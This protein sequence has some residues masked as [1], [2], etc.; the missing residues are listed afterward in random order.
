LI[1]VLP[2]LLALA[3]LVWVFFMLRALLSL[4]QLAPKGQRMQ[5]YNR[6]SMWNFGAV[7]AVVGS[8]AEPHL[9]VM[10]R[11]AYMFITL[12]VVVIAVTI[13]GIALQKPAAAQSPMPSRGAAAE[14]MQTAAKTIDRALSRLEN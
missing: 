11:G 1:A 12:F 7:R 10:K 13:A 3:G 9:L 2:P 4:I 6:L 14:A 8:G 5:V